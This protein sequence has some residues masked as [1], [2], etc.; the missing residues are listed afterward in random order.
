MLVPD[1][2]LSPELA[3]KRRPK[4]LEAKVRVNSVDRIVSKDLAKQQKVRQGIV[5]GYIAN[6]V[7]NTGLFQM[8][9]VQRLT[10]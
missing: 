6:D 4:A 3:E 1:R 7:W 2:F 10:Q 8:S 9:Y 5:L